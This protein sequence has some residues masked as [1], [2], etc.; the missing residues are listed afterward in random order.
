M[1]YRPFPFI[2]IDTE[3][4]MLSRD[5]LLN[6]FN[7]RR[8]LPDKKEKW[9][10]VGESKI[11]QFKE[12]LRYE[13]PQL[14]IE[15]RPFLTLLNEIQEKFG[16][17]FVDCEL[18]P[19]N[20]IGDDKSSFAYIPTFSVLNRDDEPAYLDF[21]F[22]T[23]FAYMLEW[24]KTLSVDY[25]IIKPVPP[26]IPK[27]RYVGKKEETDRKT[28]ELMWFYG[29]FGFH[30]LDTSYE[31]TRMKDSLYLLSNLN[32]VDIAKVRGQIKEDFFEWKDY[33]TP[34]PALSDIAENF[35][36]SD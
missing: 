15:H 28:K 8:Y 33:D 6:Q 23:N 30:E 19:V 1:D 32:E 17:T 16:L 27:I 20:L 4:K 11:Y 7:F 10:K 18:P 22:L 31:G 25:A 34:P 29:L 35:I 2:E 36:M 14:G 21:E 26:N 12:P 9:E 13:S 3:M 24:L 5:I